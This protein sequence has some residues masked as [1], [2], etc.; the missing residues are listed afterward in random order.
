MEISHSKGIN[1]THDKYKGQKRVF[2]TDD[3]YT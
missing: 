1:D 2:I 3:T